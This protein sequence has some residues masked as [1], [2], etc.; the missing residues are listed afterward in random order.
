MRWRILK[1]LCVS[2]NPAK[3]DNIYK[4]VALLVGGELS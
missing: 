4:E 1:A 2:M 3:V